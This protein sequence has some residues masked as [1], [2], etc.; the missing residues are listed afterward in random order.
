[1]RGSGAAFFVA[2]EGTSTGFA[3][4]KTGS[5]AYP[6]AWRHSFLIFSFSGFSFS[7]AVEREVAVARFFLSAPF[8]AS[9]PSGD[10]RFAPTASDA[11]DAAPS[12]GE[13]RPDANPPP[14]AKS[15]PALPRPVASLVS[16]GPNLPSAT[17]RAMRASTLSVYRDE[18][19]TGRFFS[20]EVSATSESPIGFFSTSAAF[21]APGRGAGGGAAPPGRL[22]ARGPSLARFAAMSLSAIQSLSP[23]LF[24]SRSSPTNPLASQA[25]IMCHSYG[26]C[27]TPC[28]VEAR[29][30]G[31]RATRKRARRVMIS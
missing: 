15:S 18:T 26:P 5:C 23:A 14:A 16:A 11:G 2:P 17:K 20:P 25:S 31:G 8:S 3:G 1:M 28:E 7:F 9:S 27:T 30:R 10:L 19:A 4:S 6:S 13:D 21:D 12:A 29:R 24:T 22:G